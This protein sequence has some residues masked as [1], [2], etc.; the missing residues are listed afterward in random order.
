MDSNSI[1][2]CRIAV[3][4]HK[5]QELYL[6]SEIL[7]SVFVGRHPKTGPQIQSDD[8]GDNISE[9]NYLYCEL[10]ATYWLWK[11]VDADVKG[12]FHYRRVLTD[13][14]A[15]MK[16]LRMK[17]RYHYYQ[18]KSLYNNKSFT[19]QD[20]RRVQD[21]EAY[22]HEAKQFA[23]KIPSLFN[24]QHIDVIAPT[25]M[26]S[27]IITNKQRF[28]EILD[29]DF[30][31]LIV[32]KV[33]EMAP[34]Y[35]GAFK[36]TL[37]STTMTYANIIIARNAIFDEYCRYLFSVLFAVEKAII[38]EN[39]WHDLHEK[40]LSRRF[41]YIGELLTSSFILQC[42]RKGLRVLKLPVLENS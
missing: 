16:P 27:F 3:A 31:A 36:D 42:E 12:L 38:D 33:E 24:Q 30:L 29:R 8:T 14:T 11:N 18:F 28:H 4:Y 37:S 9:K 40:S 1:K 6:E 32:R 20:K 17:L 23:E 7:T 19:I 2:C 25:N 26:M 5:E 15:F 39:Y 22:M 41:G 10:T 13:R 34:D 21:V 35:L